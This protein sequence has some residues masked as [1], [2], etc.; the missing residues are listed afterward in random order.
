[1]KRFAKYFACAALAMSA[2][3][4][5]CGAARAQAGQTPAP[6]PATKSSSLAANLFLPV[7]ETAKGAH[8]YDKADDGKSNRMLFDV[9]VLE[10]KDQDHLQLQNAKIVTFDENQKEDLTFLLP[11][12]MFNLNTYFLTTD[13]P[14]ILKRADFELMGATLELNTKTRQGK[15][16]GSVKMII[17][18]FDD[19][20]KSKETATP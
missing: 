11:V 6:T 7:G 9:G 14:F 3:C 12:S 10:R 4:A 18:H 8:F 19:F 20:G 17:F 1:M 13:Q 15:I 16:T 2:G 5:F